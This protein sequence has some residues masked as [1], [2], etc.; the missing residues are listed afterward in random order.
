VGGVD[1]LKRA[2]I[3]VHS[4]PLRARRFATTERTLWRLEKKGG[5]ERGDFFEKEN[6][7]ISR[8]MTIFATK[9]RNK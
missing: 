8:K 9:K 1:L 7:I 3:F 2:N 6:V 4:S 5:R